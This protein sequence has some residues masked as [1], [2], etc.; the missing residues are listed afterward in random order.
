MHS[1]IYKILFIILFLTSSAGA[2]GFRGLSDT[3][4]YTEP[5]NIDV[6][7]FRTINNTRNGFSDAVIPITDKTLL[8]VSIVLPLG[9]IGI[10][11]AGNNYYDENTG[12]LLMLSEITSTAVTFGMK[13][14]IKRER[15]SVTLRNV[16]VN[17]G[18]SLTDR[19]SFPSGHTSMA[20][21]IATSLTLRYTD[22]P[23]IIAGSFFYAVIIGYGRIYLGVHYPSDVFAG[24][25]I[26]AGSAALI[27]S[28]R[29]EIINGKNNLFNESGY[30]DAN[31][32]SL[33]APVILGTFI[34]ADLINFL[35]L[36]NNRM[37]VSF[38]P[39]TKIN[40]NYNF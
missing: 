38:S 36:K 37:R 31:Q 26:G 17:R 1:R 7:L 8:P 4:H 14:L 40:F 39:D 16:H 24:A 27:F 23:A 19:Y 21:S 5:N 13:T 29:K 3:S 22:K 32:K 28:L 11:R 35:I 20:F 30:P 12:V 10:G 15:P 18:N 33:S 9:L 2:Q 25:L 34:A 6:R